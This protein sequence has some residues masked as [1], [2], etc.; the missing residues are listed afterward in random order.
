MRH[1][2]VCEAKTAAF[3]SP[4]WRATS[5]DTQGQRP[6]GQA[7][8]EPTQAW[9]QKEKQAASPEIRLLKLVSQQTA[10]LWKL[11]YFFTWLGSYYSQKKNKKHGSFNSTVNTTFIHGLYLSE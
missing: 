11:R 3:L 8:C 4:L 5:Q 9:R 2:L 7:D 10:R 1:F 6:Y